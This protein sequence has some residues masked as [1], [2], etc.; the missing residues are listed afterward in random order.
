MNR[1]KR[2]TFISY[3]Q[4]LLFLSLPVGDLS[5]VRNK[6]EMRGRRRRRERVL[7]TK[8]PGQAERE[9][10]GRREGKREIAFTSSLRELCSGGN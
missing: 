3:R 8:Q 7:L 9:T 10:E 5:V 2:A 1:R 6:G 4:L